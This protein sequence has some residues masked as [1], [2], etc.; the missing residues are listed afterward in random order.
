MNKT[1]DLEWLFNQSKRV[2]CKICKSDAEKPAILKVVNPFHYSEYLTLYRCEDCG[3]FFFDPF[4]YPPYE[5]DCGYKNYAKFYVEQM[6]GIDFLIEP[7]IMLKVKNTIKLFTITML[8]VKK[9]KFLDVGCGFGFAVKFAEEILDMRAVGVDPSYYGKLGRQVL[10]VNIFNDYLENISELYEDRFDIVYSSEVIEHIPKPE[11]F[12]ELLSSYLSERGIM[13]LTTPNAHIINKECRCST[14]LGVL[15]PG[16]HAVLFTPKSVF[17]LLNKFGFENIKII[18]KAHRLL[19]FASKTEDFY[20]EPIE[21]DILIN[22]YYVPFLQKLQKTNN[23]WLRAGA[24]WRLFKEYI[25]A[26]RY[27]DAISVWEELKKELEEKYRLNFND[28]IDICRIVSGVSDF[29]K[30]GERFPYFIGGLYYYLG[31]L[32]LN[33]YADYKR[34]ANYFRISFIIGLKCLSL[35]TAYFE[36]MADLLW[37]AKFHEGLSYLY[38]GE[39][40]RAKEIFSFILANTDPKE[41]FFYIIPSQDITENCELRMQKL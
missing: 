17:Y 1:K 8:K 6:A 39:V 15:S 4:Q 21:R 3:V 24:G 19:I 2:Q 40:E 7:L 16:L 25:N 20:V 23:D 10:K 30:F 32:Y 12:I 11:T 34:S 38:Q 14:L 37:R 31:M 41:E 18:E 33:H 35:G 5:S 26:G 9:R 13:I 22:K 36:E 29:D 28:L 27:E